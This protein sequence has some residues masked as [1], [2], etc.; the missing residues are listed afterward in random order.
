VPTIPEALSIAFNHHQRGELPQAESIY[1]QIVDHEPNHADAWHLWGVAAHQAGRHEEAIAHIQRALAIGGPNA[2]FLNH[3]GAAYASLE[4]HQEAEDVFRQ[5]SSLAPNDP[6]VHY[7]LAALFNLRGNKAEAIESY[8]R[9]VALA[10]KFAEAQF[11]LGNLLRDAGDFPGAEYCFAAAL[12]ARPT[13]VKG[14][15]SLANMQLR[16][17]KHTAAEST[18]RI[19]LQVDPENVDAHYWLGSLLQSQ[20]RLDE[21]A[22][23]LQA[24]VVRNP[25]HLEAQNN[26]GCV[27]RALGRPDQAEQCFR[28]ALDAAPDFGPTLNNLGSVLH[29]RKD[30]LAAADLFRRAIAAQPEFV[31]AHNNLGTVYQDQKQFDEALK[32]YR[33]ALELQPDSAE[34]QLNVGSVLQMQGHLSE[35][36]EMY[37]RSLAINPKIAR[38]H[39]CRG[40]GLHTAGRDDEALAAYA[41]ALRLQPDYAEAH[42]NRSFVHLARG[43]LQAG[44][45]DYEWR[46]KC[47]DYKG[48][49]FPVPRWDG[50][51]LGN[52]TLLVHAEQGLGDTLHFIR[53]LKTL[54]R[55]GGC[56]YV[57]VPPPVVPLLKASGFTG[58]IPGG[59]P[60]PR[61]DVQIPLLSLPY[62]MGTTL[63]TIP[64]YVPYL[65]AEPRLI[66]Q[67]RGQ[68]R[69]QPGFKV[70]LVWQG[71]RDYAYDHF[72]SI[73]LAAYAPLGEVAGV[74]LI[75]LQK[76]YGSEQLAAL[77]GAFQVLD[78]GSSLDTT[79]GAFMDTAAVMSSLDLVI[80]SDTA[81]AHLAGGLGVPV[82]LAVAQAPEWRWLLERSDCPWYPTMRLFRQR[83]TGDWSDVFAAMKSQLAALVQKRAT[84]R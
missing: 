11:N 9:A 82:W 66:K 50:S 68:L 33:R 70:G 62:V 74:Q 5:A 19:A 55:Q 13:Y 79:S 38:T 31:E 45:E 71:N 78:W 32:C 54:Q 8:R 12:A 57:E 75:S 65:A 60:L 61:F 37:D 77:G 2:N 56:V 22:I 24:A 40:A 63:Q 18:Y 44:W 7:N 4:R 28:I 14:A 72:R 64:A 67:W 35:A 73:P 47:K 53:Y 43:D 83:T 39:Y 76:G 23:E 21:A 26:L 16:L 41:E 15:L 3:L 51:P 17:N 25:R 58:V 48:R 29:D 46:L 20:Q 69:S 6:Q 30:Y 34:A 49:Q 10:P 36:L 27:F 81:T 52:R 80:S 84:S 1:R 59:S 42:Y